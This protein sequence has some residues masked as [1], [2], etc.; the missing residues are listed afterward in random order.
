MAANLRAKLPTGDKFLINDVN[1]A[2]T[3]KFVQ[4]VGIVATGTEGENEARAVEVVDSP[5]EIAERSVSVHYPS[6]KLYY[7][8]MMNMFFLLL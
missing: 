5:R 4:E 3:A 6:R 1:K 2:A 8:F 7:L